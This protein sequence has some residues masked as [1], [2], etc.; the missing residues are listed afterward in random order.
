MGRGGIAGTA[1]ASEVGRARGDEFGSFHRRKFLDRGW[2]KPDRRVYDGGGQ[3]ANAFKRILGNLMHE[4]ERQIAARF[5]L[6]VVGEGLEAEDFVDWAGGEEAA[7]AGGVDPGIIV[8]DDGRG[9]EGVA[10]VAGL[11][12]DEDG[13][14]AEVA[15]E[16]GGLGVGVGGIDHGEEGAVADAEDGVGGGEGAQG[17]FV[18]IVEAGARLGGAV[19]EADAD[20]GDGGG[21]RLGAEFDEARDGL[22]LADDD[23]GDEAGLIADGLEG[24]GGGEGEG[25]FAR[26]IEEILEG[27]GGEVD[28]ALD[29]FPA[30]GVGPAVHDELGDDVEEIGVVGGG[31]VAQG[32]GEFAEAAAE[33]MEEAGG[34]FERGGGEALDEAFGPHG[35][36]LGAELG[37]AVGLGVDAAEGEAPGVLRGGGAAGIEDVA[38]VEDGVD[39]GIDELLIHGGA[40]VGSSAG[41]S[42]WRARSRRGAAK[43]RGVATGVALCP[44]RGGAGAESMT[45]MGWGR[46][47]KR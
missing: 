36:G 24:A 8:E 14:G 7:G 17:E 1:G 10:F 20:P 6:F 41:R 35:A 15:A 3:V 39:D 33:G 25:D 31:Q 29:D 37:A 19:D 5:A 18:R 9:E 28:G 32:D 42:C 44:S 2:G 4:G 22:L 23:A 11:V 27:E 34:D 26:F 45:R 47:R 38:L 13:P 12:A 21:D 43:R 40:S 46:R 30:A 16:G